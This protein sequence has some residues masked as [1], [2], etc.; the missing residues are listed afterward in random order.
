MVNMPYFVQTIRSNWKICIAFTT[1]MCIFLIVVSNVFTPDTIDSLTKATDGT[2]AGNI[3]TGD[4]TLISFLSNSF[5]AL[6]AVIFP[7][8]YS[9]IVGN[10]LIAEK[11]DNGN[12]AGF[13]ATPVARYEI[14]LAS[15]LYLICSLIVM[16][17]LTTVTGIIA[18][19]G[20]QPGELDVDTF[21][22]M[23]LGAFLYS[24][25]ISSI[26]FFSSC[27]FNTSKNSL[28]LGGGVPLLFF[29]VSLMVKLSEDL[30]FL[31]YFT[32]NTLF[33]TEEILEGS[34]YGP[35]FIILSLISLIL[36]SAGILW[37]QKKDLPI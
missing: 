37:F 33:D 26:C 28:M 23:N 14:T 27:V 31:K 11:V 18:A 2:L 12:M 7:M 25:A 24:L 9:I 35:D 34:G 19:H 20:F 17:G 1:V 36:Y 3:L 29:A 5:Y 6:M 22:V 15:A 13:L 10:R 32:L 16:W 8:A 4:G 30:D 21:L